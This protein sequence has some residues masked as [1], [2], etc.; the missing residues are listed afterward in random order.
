MNRVVMDLRPFSTD[1]AKWE[2]V[3]KHDAAADGAF[4]YSVKT[5]G[6]YCRPSCAARPARPEN[7]GFHATTADAERAG[8]RPCR[9]CRPD[10]PPRAEREAAVVAAACRA[11]DGAEEVLKLEDLAAQAGM[12]P[13]HFHRVFKRITGVTPKAYAC[14]QLQRRV[15]AELAAGNG[16]TGALYAAGYNSAARFY[17]A[18]P[19]ML[20]MKPSQYRKGGAGESIGVATGQSSLGT[21]LV[22]ATGQ[23][24]CAILLG[25]DEAALQA[26]LRERFPRAAFA[27]AGP[28]FAGMLAQVIALVDD[29]AHAPAASLPLDVR[30]TAF[31]RRVWEALQQIPAGATVT[32]TELAERAGNRKA[33]RAVASACAA[34]SIAVAIPCHR[35]IAADGRLAGYR[36][37]IDRKR[38]LLDR[39]RR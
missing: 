29:P 37:G 17:E 2:A 25:D 1:A 10:L 14:A 22:A 26:D 36:W 7:V 13:H 34:N 30:G 32:Y 3:R 9:R 11:M 16:V 39:E 33:V 4:F 8:F 27:D 21:V 31:Q 19:R 20:G 38:A 6:V 15:Q 28:N 35:A 24:V 23:G 18:A 5:T 12:S